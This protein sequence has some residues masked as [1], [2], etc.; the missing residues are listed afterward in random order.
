M[1]VD[2]TGEGKGGISNIV[3]NFNL[4][5]IKIKIKN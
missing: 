3:M 5:K 4:K 1:D 2:F